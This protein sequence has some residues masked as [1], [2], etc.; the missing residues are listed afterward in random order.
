MKRDNCSYLEA[1][2]WTLLV[3]TNVILQCLLKTSHSTRLK[4]FYETR[5]NW[6][7]REPLKYS[8]YHIITGNE[9]K[10][11]HFFFLAFRIRYTLIIKLCHHDERTVNDILNIDIN[12][13]KRKRYFIDNSIIASTTSWGDFTNLITNL[14]TY[15]EKVRF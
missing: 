5:K 1:I 10:E 6:Y 2:K 9:K 3:Y 12:I 15:L 4:D 7:L 8:G 14:I 11:K 13:L